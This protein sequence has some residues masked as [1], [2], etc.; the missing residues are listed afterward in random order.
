LVRVSRSEGGSV[1]RPRRLP[2]LVSKVIERTGAG[3]PA[4]LSLESKTL[5]A[6]FA[7]STAGQIKV[8][9]SIVFE[10][11]FDNVHRSTRHRSGVATP[12]PR[13]HR[14]RWAKPFRETDTLETLE[15]MMT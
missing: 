14:I 10:V 3:T 2:A 8:I 13:I 4:S 11:A 6:P 5:G 7:P 15:R 12:F 9:S 1:A